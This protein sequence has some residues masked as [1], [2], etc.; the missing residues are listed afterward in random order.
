MVKLRKLRYLTLLI[1]I[2]SMMILS[3]FVSRSPLLRMINGIVLTL[4]LLS[5]VYTVKS[6]KWTFITG[7]ILGIPWVI[8]SWVRLMYPDALP[9]AVQSITAMLF[10]GFV[11]FVLLRHII[12]TK[13]ITANIIYGS[14]SVYIIL[15]V[16]FASL[17][18]FLTSVIQ[19]PLFEYVGTGTDT[20]A[21]DPERLFYF[22][23]VTLTTL[24]YGDIRPV[25]D[26]TR[27]LAVIEAM[28]GVLYSATLIGRLIGLYVAQS[29]KSE[30]AAEAASRAAAAAAAAAD[31]AATDDMDVAEA[32]AKTASRAAADAAEAAESAKCENDNGDG[33]DDSCGD[34]TDSS[35]PDT[36]R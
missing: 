10:D 26:I 30:A 18:M 28:T 11:I 7:L 15:G 34:D 13:K 9:P 16:F 5:V 32:A 27:I 17:Y 14:I 35:D 23:F 8:E 31:A 24:G 2:V 20:G 19:A 29:S 36:N 12:R 22:S 21:A 6:E 33:A 3:P 1:V 4:M 25:S